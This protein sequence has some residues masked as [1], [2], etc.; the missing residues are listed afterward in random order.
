[1]P[2]QTPVPETSFLGAYARKLAFTDCYSTTVPGNTS[3]PEFIEAFYTTPL[4]KIERWLLAKALNIQSRDEDASKLARKELTRFSAW[5][6]E[7][8]SDS[9]ILL[10]AG[11]TRSWLSVSPQSAV[12][13]ETT[14][15]FGSAVVPL[16]PG[17][18]FG[19]AFY[20]LLGFHRLYSRLLLASAARNVVA[21]RKLKSDA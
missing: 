17:G 11:Q 13:S 16:R 3:L 8:R 1:M 10:D 12:K 6:V 5:K 4:F 7:N 20:A 19:L 9:E 2:T 15:L 21:A 18:K 14:L